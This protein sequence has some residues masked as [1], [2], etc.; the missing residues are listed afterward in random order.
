MDR[1]RPSKTNPSTV[2]KNGGLF[3][4]LA[5]DKSGNTIA[6]IAA[7]TAPLLALIGGGI[8]MSRSYLSQARLQQAC[9]AGVLAAR[10]KLG[11]AVV[12]DGLVPTDVVDAGNRFFNLNYRDG[13]YG[14]ADRSFVMGLENDYSISGDAS[15]N[16]PTTIMALFG[17]DKMAIDVTCEAQLNFSDTDV[18]FVLDTT[19]SMNETNPGDSVTRIDALRTVVKDFHAQ[20]EGSKSPTTRIRYGFVPYATNVN[21]GA[22]L[23]DDWVVDEWTYQSR[24]RKIIGSSVY[25]QRNWDNW[26][27]ISGSYS[28][29]TVD[30]YNAT[31]H[32][33]S[34]QPGVGE[35]G[36]AGSSGGYYTCNRPKPSDTRNGNDVLLSEVSEPYPGPPAG[37]KVTKHYRRTT[38][39]SSYWTSRSGGQCNIRRREYNNYIQEFD[40]ITYPAAGTDETWLYKPVTRD[41]SNWRNE[42]QGCM[43]ERDTYEI[44]SMDE[45]IDFNRALDLDLDRVPTAGTP[46]TQWR[47]MYPDIIWAR[48][49]HNAHASNFMVAE[50]EYDW[51]YFH[52]ADHSTLVACPVPSRKL[53]EMDVST[54]ASYMDS[55]VPQGQT[56]HDIGMIWGGRLLSPTGLFAAEN[57]D[58]SGKTTSRHLIFLTD[59]VTEPLDISYTSYGLEPIDQRR[60]TN[61]PDPLLD[62]TIELRFGLACNEVKKRNISVWIIGFGTT[63]NDIMKN[64]AGDG[65]WFQANDA[66]E[67]AETFNKIAKSLGELRVSK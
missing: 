18:M 43:E 54:V 21:V 41:V 2:L 56:Y 61:R 59:G 63:M 62:R 19:G 50:Q 16:V 67:L 13:A 29:S 24:E 65:H 58:L 25:T 7:S 49:L 20:L 45:A 10:K 46:S 15:V 5:R 32:P 9:D 4:R 23:E 53:A 39:G 64:C 37:T 57:A 8:D 42:T 35:G 40:L 55:L 30:T 17:T 60:W 52:P 38:T 11:S 66:A 6:L 1:T 44:Y 47:P 12:N 28:D 27:R 34:N 51:N 3:R 31:W 48:A 36:S 26:T 33:G 14:T 22:L